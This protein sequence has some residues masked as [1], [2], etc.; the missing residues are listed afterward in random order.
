M[1]KTD[2]LVY[3]RSGEEF[4]YDEEL[5]DDLED[6]EVYYV[7]TKVI[8]EPKDLITGYADYITERVEEEL[9]YYVGD[10]MVDRGIMTQATKDKL[11]TTISNFLYENLSIDAYLVVDTKECAFHLD[12]E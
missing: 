5:L 6:G 11:D 2:E 8:I 9:Y 3:S 4:D 1:I 12:E 10:A 7:G